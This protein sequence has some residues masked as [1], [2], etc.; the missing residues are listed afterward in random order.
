MSTPEHNRSLSR[1][2]EPDGAAAWSTRWP[3]WLAARVA[4]VLF[5][6]PGLAASVAVG[7]RADGSQSGVQPAVHA[8]PGEHDEGAPATHDGAPAPSE[9]GAPVH[10]DFA[11]VAS[12][13]SMTS[14]HAIAPTPVL[15]ADLAE[16]AARLRAS[17]DPI[18]R[19]LASIAA[20]RRPYTDGTW[21][22]TDALL[23]LAEA[24]RASGT[25]WTDDRAYRFQIA[26]GDRRFYGDDPDGAATFYEAALALHPGEA[27]ATI[28]L[29]RVLSQIFVTD[30]EQRLRRALALIDGVLERAD[31]M[32]PVMR[33][34]LHSDRAFIL[35][36]LD[37]KRE[38]LRAINLALDISLR[39][40]HPE[41]EVHA[42]VIGERETANDHQPPRLE[43]FTVF[44]KTYPQALSFIRPR[45]PLFAT[46]FF[47]RANILNEWRQEAQALEAID[48]AI[49]IDH[50]HVPNDH[51]VLAAKHITR[52]HILWDLERIDEA[53]EA[54]DAAFEIA[55]R[56]LWFHHPV[57]T[58]IHAA[59]AH[60]LQ[61]LE[62]FDDALFEL[63]LVMKAAHASEPLSPELMTEMFWLRTDLLEELERFDEA[64]E[65]ATRTIEHELRKEQPAYLIVADLHRYRAE[66]L[67][68]LERFDEALAAL[69]EVI[70]SER[71][72]DPVD[73][74][75]IAGAFWDRMR[76]LRSL[77]RYGEALEA[78]DRAIE[79]ERE[80][81]EPDDLQL[82]SSHWQRWNILRMLERY[83]EALEAM[84]L[85]IAIELKH[86]P[87]GSA[88]I[89]ESFSTRGTFLKGLGRFGEALEAKD[90]AVEIW[91]RDAHTLDRALADRFYAMTMA[92]FDGQLPEAVKRL[93]DLIQRRINA[94]GP[95]D[96]E[97]EEL[98]RFLDRF[99]AELA[100]QIS[101]QDNENE[102]GD[103]E[104]ERP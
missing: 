31:A 1:A 48:R 54:T 9:G 43:A 26:C 18:D 53:L 5:V 20:V 22:E 59:R 98:R 23:A 62:R 60:M 16:A 92:Y 73:Q 93:E 49:W 63:D 34:T 61:D 91:D 74:R 30:R 55:A 8:A 42:G 56:N 83:D 17:E 45:H 101:G 33:A 57:F 41:H 76:L 66:L 86:E 35:L 94:Y 12:G 68:D 40:F 21:A 13:L 96:G 2:P 72:R 27:T 47:I 52:A 81:L 28:R 103:E 75:P 15:T 78:I 70:A 44:D 102:R 99:H 3:R 37:R 77:E 104:D 46:Q 24:E 50:L 32:D 89:A 79:I 29:A 85:A 100:E 7:S 58:N 67:E 80:F 71:M 95:D 36:L 10:D 90:R 84:D 14:G 65:A 39:H 88:S 4:A 38:A 19:A 87:S 82:A 6:M 64:L 97:L 11:R 25:N 69:D 51:P